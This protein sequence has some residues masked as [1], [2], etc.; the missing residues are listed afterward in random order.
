MQ[1]N[2]QIVYVMGGPGSGK[3]THSGMLKDKYRLHH[4]SSGDLVRA[5][6]AAANSA[7]QQSEEDKRISE[8]TAKGAFLPDQF[9]IDIIKA[10]IAAHPEAK[11]FIID[12][13]PRTMEQHDLFAAQIK[14]CDKILFFNTSEAIMKERMLGRAEAAKLAGEAVRPDDNAETAGKRIDTFRE[15]TMPVITALKEKFSQSEKFIEINTSGKVDEV[16]KLIVAAMDRDNVEEPLIPAELS[17]AK[18]PAASVPSSPAPSSPAPLPSSPDTVAP[19]APSLAVAS[20]PPSLPAVESIPP[21]EEVK[22]LHRRPANTAV[23]HLAPRGTQIVDVTVFELTRLYIKYH[24][25]C[26]AVHELEEKHN[27]VNFRVIVPLYLTYF[28]AGYIIQDT[29]SVRQI[30]SAN[31]RTGFQNHNFDLA[32]GQALNINA[33]QAFAGDKGMAHNPLWEAIHKQLARHVGDREL[34]NKLMDKHIYSFLSLQDFDL[35]IEFEKFMSKMWCEYMFGDKVNPIQF[36]KTRHKFLE[37]MRYAFY[38]NKL[39]NVPLLGGLSSRFWH[40]MKQNEFQEICDEV[41]EYIIQADS[42]LVFRFKRGLEQDS[43]DFPQSRIQEALIANSII[44]M[45]VFD[46]PLNALYETLAAVANESIQ[47]QEKRKDAYKPALQRSFLFPW[48]VRIPQQPVAVA[49]GS[50]ASNHW[51]FINLLKSELYHSWGIRSCIGAGVTSWIKDRLFEHL[52]PIRLNA[53]SMSCPEDRKQLC[54]CADVPRSPERYRIRWEYPRDHLQ[55][56]LPHHEFKGLKEFYD[57]LKTYEN[58]ALNAYI[59]ST[60]LLKIKELHLEHGSISV[61]TPEVRGIAAGAMVADREGFPL[62]HIRKKG[63]IPGGVFE[64]SYRKAY[65]PDGV[66]ILEVIQLSD[67]SK[68]KGKN[69]ILI[70]DGIASGATTLACIKAIEQAGGKVALI[71]TMINHT[72]TPRAAE[73]DRYNIHT[74]FD[75]AK[76]VAQIASEGK[77]EEM[78]EVKEAKD[79]PAATAAKM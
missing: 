40:W 56:V 59:A 17:S 23:I 46:F 21:F 26:D 10:E 51:V 20:L 33:T 29:Q 57:V 41:A 73:L 60:F 66:I 61:V 42:G 19:S 22:L 28:I 50:V 52:A 49:S 75:F 14:P 53:L 34:I 65:G 32:L 7:P 43:P 55:K 69:V 67:T 76:P 48:R 4:I 9:I 15:K 13:C 78:K 1:R 64:A 3:G 39:K 27:T 70:D 18:E 47:D 58:P 25:F 16:A 74:L 72:Y 12:G 11:G 8:M 54:H 38:N 71:L 77:V 37:A 35:D 63:S 6:I 36:E 31:T 79:E 68:V 62:V 45:L 5:R 44:L 24:N 30:L 2:M